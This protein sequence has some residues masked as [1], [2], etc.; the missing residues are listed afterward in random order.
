M[1]L[2]YLKKD[3][4]DEVDI[5]HKHQ[6]FLQTNFNTLGIKVSRKFSIILMDMI[7]YSQSTESKK[8]AIC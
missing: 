2:E 8:F 3:V 4:T 5:L 7:K 6:S 1:S